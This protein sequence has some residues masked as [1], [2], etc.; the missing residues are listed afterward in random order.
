MHCFKFRLIS[1][2]SCKAATVVSG[3]W[4]FRRWQERPWGGNPGGSLVARWQ[5]APWWQ[6]RWWGKP[7]LNAAS[8]SGCHSPGVKLGLLEDG[9]EHGADWS[10]EYIYSPSCGSLCRRTRPW[11][12]AQC[13]SSS[14]RRGS[15]QGR[16]GVLLV[17][18]KGH[19]DISRE[20]CR[21]KYILR[22][23]SSSAEKK[24]ISAE[25]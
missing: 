18:F 12:S 4:G 9:T 5:V 21:T 17:K 19:L 25:F 8:L 6:L 23:S 16:H 24:L 7:L 15:C 10:P 1:C 13:S 14:S 20:K 2:D 22:S 11:W 3:L